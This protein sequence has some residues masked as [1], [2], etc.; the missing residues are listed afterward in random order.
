MS[1]NHWKGIKAD[2]NLAENYF[3]SDP[4]AAICKEGG[5]ACKVLTPIKHF[6]RFNLDSA[7]IY[8]ITNK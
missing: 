1:L 5:N 8:L 4:E 3:L 6:P 2:L 7:Y